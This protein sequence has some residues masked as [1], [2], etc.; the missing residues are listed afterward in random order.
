MIASQ[1]FKP[2]LDGLVQIRIDE[3]PLPAL[4]ARLE[5]VASEMAEAARPTNP[6]LG[7]GREVLQEMRKALFGF[8][9]DEETRRLKLEHHA[10]LDKAQAT[11]PLIEPLLPELA[12]YIERCTGIPEEV[13]SRFLVI[14]PL[15]M[16]QAL[17]RGG[18]AFCAD[19]LH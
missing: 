4:E 19:D 18:N 17:R 3:Q 1:D 14:V 11:L 7:K 10:R 9:C 12:R 6:N 15:L 13:L 5:A 8:L 16:L 2:I